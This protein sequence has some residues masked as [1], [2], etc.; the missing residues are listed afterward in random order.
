MLR[1]PVRSDRLVFVEASAD[2]E[3]FRPNEAWGRMVREKYGLGG[4]VVVGYVGTFAGWHGIEDLIHASLIVARRCP[5]VRFLM[6][7]PNYEWA[8][9][10]TAERGVKN[11]F[12]FTG[13]IPYD[14][15]PWFINAADVLVAPYNPARSEL[16]RR[17]GIGSPLKLF[18]YMACGKPVVATAVPPIRRVVRDGVNALLVPPGDVNALADAIIRL[19]EDPP[20]AGRLGKTARKEVV[21]RYSWEHFA[22]RLQDLMGEVLEETALSERGGP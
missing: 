17:Y 13:P 21:G 11:L 16:R 2:T 7:G 1:N 14:Q 3:K 9:R 12:T 4:A 20:F 19:I 22:S 8:E 6:V 15:V 10:L 18:E 5:N